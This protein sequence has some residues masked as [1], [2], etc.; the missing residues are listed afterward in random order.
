DVS[1]GGDSDVALQGSTIVGVDG[2]AISTFG[3]SVSLH[4]STLTGNAGDGIASDA[5]VTVVNST[6]SDNYGNGV[7]ANG[8]T[9]FV[10]NSTVT[11]NQGDGVATAHSVVL[12]YA[13]ITNND[14]AHSNGQNL[15]FNGGGEFAMFATVISGVA[16]NC[17]SGTF[18]SIG[19]NF[20][21]DS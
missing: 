12:V 14:Q 21:D 15:H 1:S 7:D 10:V 3:G 11:G 5:N 4:N 13:T 6:A 19:F 9:N 8:A 2:T 17:D 20:S 16:P 18:N